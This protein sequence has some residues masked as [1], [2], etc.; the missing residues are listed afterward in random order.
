MELFVL[1]I[2]NLLTTLVIY[3][4]FSMKFSRSVQLARKHALTEDLRENIEAAIEY[5]NTALDLMDRRSRTYYQ[6]VRK[7]EEILKKI[8]AA[9]ESTEGKKR[10]KGRKSSAAESA[11]AVG[12]TVGRAEARESEDM[13][14]AE[15]KRLERLLGKTDTHLDIAD[16]PDSVDAI[17][18]QGPASSIGAFHAA[19]SL[20]PGGIQPSAILPGVA[21]NAFA[22]L[23]RMVGRL[24]GIQPSR[25]DSEPVDRSSSEKGAH[26]ILETRAAFEN[27]AKGKTEKPVFDQ[28][29]AESILLQ[30]RSE[31]S[32]EDSRDDRTPYF[33]LS[34]S[35]SHNADGDRLEIEHRIDRQPDR[36]SLEQ[37]KP[38]NTRIQEENRENTRSLFADVEEKIHEKEMASGSSFEPHLDEQVELLLHELRQIPSGRLRGERIRTLLEMGVSAQSIVEGGSV[39]RTEVDLVAAFE[40]ARSLPRRK[41][42]EQ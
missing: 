16:L 12:R 20:P 18:K 42:L 14:E 35:E 31:R 30:S 13:S 29:M 24:M 1:I 36:F 6:L 19:T 5:I 25:S 34:S 23:G 37:A 40:P 21:G 8:E 7:S 39:S 38:M 22:R 10:K 3:L 9:N 17:Y 15:Q 33:P 4:L 32:S 26:D 28:I 41:R 27:P 2:V 11:D